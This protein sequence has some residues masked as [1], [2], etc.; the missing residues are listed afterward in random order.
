MA[1]GDAALIR[2]I[3]SFEDHP[4]WGARM[5]DELGFRAGDLLVSTTEGGETPYVI[6]ATERAAEVSRR[7]P[8]FLY[9]NPD[10]LL[11]KAAERSR[12]VLENPRVHAVN[13]TVGPMAITGSTRMQAST[14][15]MAAVGWAV[16]HRDA[17]ARIAAS[18][19]SFR[20]LVAGAD[21]AALAPFVAREATIYQNG[22]RVL[23]DPGP[24]GI[25][26]V[27][28]TTERSPTFT[29]TPFEN[30]LKPS[31]PA[32]LCYV[33]FPDAPDAAAAWRALLG[34]DPR[35][36]E[37]GGLAA[38]TGMATITGYDFSARA[39]GLRAAR[40]PESEH[41]PFVVRREGG[42][43]TWRLDGLEARWPL[44]GEP[45]FHH[46]LLLKVLLNAHSTL[47]MGRLGRYEGN[48]MTYV[49][50]SNYKLIDRAARY[51]RLL[52]ARDSLDPAYADVVRT[53][54]EVRPGLAPDEPVVPAAAEALR[55]RLKEAT[56]P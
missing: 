25:T 51:V 9:C 46:H 5:L 53:L 33:Y 54:F 14:A 34:R 4:E 28:D 43:L 22:S 15:L 38:R 49:S 48:V 19:E 27:T 3:E 7:K 10:D 1:G 31:E 35:S 52:L 32:A 42:D 18:L 8:F 21:F 45:A 29:L 17:P 41:F 39:P 13:L 30:T 40:A 24:F 2:S 55:A 47:V 12:H 16:N 36:L 50:P 37:W 11:A 56:E 20:G 23:Y 44:G 6:G 26:V